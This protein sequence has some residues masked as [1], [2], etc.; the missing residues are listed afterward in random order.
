MNR[1]NLLTT[2]AASVMLPGAVMAARDDQVAHP[3]ADLLAACAAF[4]AL[5]RAYI[6]VPGDFWPDTPEERASE[7]ERERISAAQDPLVERMCELRAFTREGQAA[8]ARSL[9][10]WDAELMK[11][12][13]GDTGT[14]LTAA[15]VRDLISDAAI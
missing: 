6:A 12:G 1:R 10:L 2:A 5:E 15:I 3:D 13:P 14:W 7:A 4:D 9:A 11:P 8:R